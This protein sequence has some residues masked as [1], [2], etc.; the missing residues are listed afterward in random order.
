LRRLKALLEQVEQCGIPRSLIRYTSDWV[1]PPLKRD[2]SELPQ[3]VVWLKA[4][5]SPHPG[6]SVS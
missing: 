6:G 5:D 4:F 1:E 2:G 3:D